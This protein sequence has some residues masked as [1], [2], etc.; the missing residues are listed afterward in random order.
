[1]EKLPY[2]GWQNKE[3][4]YVSW[5]TQSSHKINAENYSAF[6]FSINFLFKPFELQLSHH[7]QPQH[8]LDKITTD[9]YSVYPHTKLHIV[10][11]IVAQS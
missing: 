10:L 4:K 11:I 1:M 7:L 5:I 9:I 3:N 6:R 2:W 8:P